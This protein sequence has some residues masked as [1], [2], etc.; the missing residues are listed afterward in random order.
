M[1]SA[2]GAPGGASIPFSLTRP[3]ERVPIA[4]LAFQG[5]AEQLA[6]P[7]SASAGRR[8]RS[9]AAAASSAADDDESDEEVSNG[10][11]ADFVD[12]SGDEERKEPHPRAVAQQRAASSLSAAQHARLS[13]LVARHRA[14]IPLHTE[15]GDLSSFHQLLFEAD[16]VPPPLE[17]MAAAWC[18]PDEPHTLDEEVDAFTYTQ[19]CA[20][21]FLCGLDVPKKQ[22]GQAAR[23][24]DEGATQGGGARVCCEQPTAVRGGCA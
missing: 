16:D 22:R 9:L 12:E 7:P 11:D 2:R 8:R 23:A 1:S 15:W 24:A 3:G 10:A 20:L 4:S 19:L 6:A 21:L 13:E 14:Q 18:K 5:S 17:F